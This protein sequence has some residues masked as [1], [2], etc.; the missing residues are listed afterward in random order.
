MNKVEFAKLVGVLE[1]AYKNFK[2]SDNKEA[3]KLWYSMLEGIPFELA[4]Y[5]V[6]KV[7]AE[8]DYDPKISTIL[9]ACTESCKSLTVTEAWEEVTKAIRYSG[10]YQE[11]AAMESMSETT[12]KVVGALGW[13]ELCTSENIMAER[14]HFIKM[15]EIYDQRKKKD[16]LLPQVD[17]ERLEQLKQL[18]EGI[19]DMK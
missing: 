19:G 5:G 12:R 16:A 1:L 4:S 2:L 8:S 7:I 18:T 6:R 14:A 15:Y 11:T 17:R 9:K 13:Q 3:M 10:Y